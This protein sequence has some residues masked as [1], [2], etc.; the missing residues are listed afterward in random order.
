MS[1]FIVLGTLVFVLETKV[2]RRWLFNVT[3]SISRANPAY[4]LAVVGNFILAVMGV[5]VR[6]CKIE[7]EVR[8][9]RVLCHVAHAPSHRLRKHTIIFV[10]VVIILVRIFEA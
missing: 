1:V 10:V 5:R 6:M 8:V 4:Q 9:G 3:T 2:Y 7:V